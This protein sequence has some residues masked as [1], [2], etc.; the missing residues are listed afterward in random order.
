MAGFQSSG[1]FPA[2]AGNEGVGQAL[3]VGKN[4]KDIA[5]ND[6]V[7]P[8]VS[9]VGTWATHVVAP[10][11]HLCKVE[12]SGS[13]EQAAVSV[14][15]PA[16]AHCLLKFAELEEGDVIIQNNAASTVGQVVQQLAAERG[17]VVVNVMRDHPEWEE[18]SAH[19]QGLNP[20]GITVSEQFARS[21][22]FPKLLKDLPAPKLALDGTG[23][24]MSIAI[25]RALRPGGTMVTYGNVSKKPVTLPM[26]LLLDRGVVARGFNLDTWARRVGREKRNELIRKVTQDVAAGKL[27]QLVAW[28]PFADFNHAL[29]RATKDYE[30]K[31]VLVM[32][33]KKN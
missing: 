20:A 13:V 16:L 9:G 18:L 31:V 17:L 23:G 4:V 6:W 22:E 24:A 30:R 27:K 33:P 2:T 19:F 25:A 26:D 21:A 15:S 28:E 3:K 7:V 32:N 11:E 14:V 5:V 12:K 1:V 10:A 8:G 29:K